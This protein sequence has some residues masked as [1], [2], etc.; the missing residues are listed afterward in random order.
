[1]PTAITALLLTLALLWAGIDWR[2]AWLVVPP[3]GV[4]LAL[5]QWWA[6]VC[7]V[8]PSEKLSAWQRTRRW[9]QTRGAPGGLMELL[10]LSFHLQALGGLGLQYDSRDT[11]VE[12][13]A[14]LGNCIVVLGVILLLQVC[15]GCVVGSA[16]ILLA[17][18]PLQERAI[19]PRAAVWGGL[20]WLARC[21]A[22][23]GVLWIVLICANSRNSLDLVNKLAQQGIQVFTQARYLQEQMRVNY[24]FTS[25]QGTPKPA[26]HEL[27]RPKS[28]GQALAQSRHPADRWSHVALTATAKAE[29]KSFNE[30]T[31]NFD[32][33][34]TVFGIK[35]ALAQ[36]RPELAK[37]IVRVDP[38]SPAD[39][40]GVKR[41][42][43]LERYAGESAREES[44]IISQ[45]A[46]GAD[47]KPITQTITISAPAVY[48]KSMVSDVSF[49]LGN[50]LL[51]DSPKKSLS[52]SPLL[53][54]QS[55]NGLYLAVHG[56]DLNLE[57]EFKRKLEFAYSLAL[58]HVPKPFFMR[59]IETVVLDLRSNGGGYTN[60]IFPFA[61]ALMGAQFQKGKFYYEKS[62]DEYHP[63]T[64]PPKTLPIKWYVDKIDRRD[65]LFRLQPK[66]LI[67]LTSP[68]TC[69]AAELLIH[70]IREQLRPSSQIIVIGEPTCGK[71][72][73]YPKH[74]YFGYQHVVI[75]QA[76]VDAQG[77][78]AYPNGIQPN[79]IARDDFK[80]EVLS[81]HDALWEPARHVIQTGQ[82]QAVKPAK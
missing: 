33:G 37:V 59:D 1:M 55:I 11:E 76:T 58:G 62:L 26:W 44:V 19:L 77:Q 34:I 49:M 70:G 56:F 41:G 53:S 81:K 42:D 73:G 51:E 22:W 10:V 38:G 79:C 23:G 46:N 17:N 82:C 2:W 47:G 21:A 71:P 32:H 80:S 43:V 12:W 63:N 52:S 74:T 48:R 69:S 57:Q 60:T 68:Y 16:R 29:G 45:A 67:V 50:T 28:I 36:G 3:L 31:E 66:R 27:I 8:S 40:A 75:N 25:V 72:Y 39:K 30:E 64:T 35:H 65:P 13:V 6:A 20:R 15:L 78:P 18:K 7:F 61:H 4:A 5:R 24:L 54:S 14:I 9:T